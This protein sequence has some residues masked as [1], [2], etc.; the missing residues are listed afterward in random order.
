[1]TQWQNEK[2]R[3]HPQGFFSTL[4]KFLRPVARHKAPS[5]HPHHASRSKSPAPQGSMTRI[6]I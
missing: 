6:K 5:R 2:R 3:N 4:E 1:M